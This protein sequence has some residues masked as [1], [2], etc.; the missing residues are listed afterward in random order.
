VDMLD[1]IED[2]KSYEEE[3]KRR[4]RIEE[5]KFFLNNYRKIHEYIGKRMESE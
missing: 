2:L 1:L 5:K 4:R 3:E